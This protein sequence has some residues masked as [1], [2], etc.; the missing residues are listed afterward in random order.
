MSVMRPLRRLYVRSGLQSAL[1]YATKRAV[2]RRWLSVAWALGYPISSPQRPRPTRSRPHRKMSI[3][4]VLMACDL[5]PDYLDYWP[6]TRRAWTEI[7][8]IEPMLVLISDEDHVPSALRADPYVIVVPPLPEAHTALQAQCIRLLYPTVVATEDAVL[9]SD[10]DLYP[11]SRSYFVDPVER[12][13]DRLFVSYR[14]IRLSRGEIDMMFNAATPQTWSEVFGVSTLED[15]LLRLAEWTSGIEYHG[16]RAWPGWYTDQQTLYRMLTG[17]PD[18]ATRWWLMDDDYTRFRRLERLELER[19]QGL[20]ARHREGLI[21]G[22]YTDYTCLF[23]YRE[24]RETNDL[25]LELGL[26]AARRASR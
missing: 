23:P 7:V 6:H 11:L 19:E 25:V 10:V 18:A 24:H 17:W 4:R 26:E 8:R 13:D 20:Q 3:G 15:V 16:G 21:R 22:A 9:I 14:D 2:R 1:P 5:N 12:L